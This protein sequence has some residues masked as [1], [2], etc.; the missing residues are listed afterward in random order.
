[1]TGRLGSRF[2]DLR[3]SIGEPFTVLYGP[4]VD[5]TFVGADYQE[6]NLDAALWHLLRA[7]SCAYVAFSSQRRPL[8][9]L[10][11]DSE[12]RSRPGGRGRTDASAPPRT[13]SAESAGPDGSAG[14]AGS[15]GP[16]LMRH[17]R[18]RGPLGRL[19]VRPPTGARNVAPAGERTTATAEPGPPRTLSDPFTVMT[20]SGYLAD[21]PRRTAVV[22]TD[23]ESTLRHTDATRPLDTFFGD[24][25]RHGD[26]DH[27]IVLV[28]A[29]ETFGDCVEYVESLHGYPGL[30]ARLR[31]Q[32]AP[33]A[34][35]GY[36]DEA[37]LH[38][39][40]QRLRLRHGLRIGSWRELDSVVR[41]MAAQP[42]TVKNWRSNLL[43]LGDTPLSGK[44]LAERGW[45]P[46]SA[47]QRSGAPASR[48]TRSAEEQL[49]DL[50]GLE[51]VKKHL[52]ELR[53]RVVNEQLLRAEGRGMDAERGSPHLLFAGPPGTG[54]T[55]VARLVGEMYREM[56]VLSHGDVVEA[57]LDDMIAGYVGQTADQA[58][59]VMDRAMNGVLFLDEVHGLSSENGSFDRDLV[60]PLLTRLENDRD[61]FV[62]IAA[63][64]PDKIDEF[65]ASDHGFPRRFGHRID[66]PDYPPDVLHTILLRY[67]ATSGLAWD[68]TVA[69]QLLQVVT[70]LYATRRPD[71]GNA[72][73]MRELSGKIFT[74]WANRVG[75]D[76][77]QPL[78]IE[79]LPEEYRGL[80]PPPVPAHG[81]GALLAELDHMVGL[82][83]VREAITGLADRIRLRQ[84]RGRSVPA[85][86]NTLFT[87]PP[88][89]GKTS[90]ARAVGTM[91][92]G[93]GL[94]RRGHVVEVTRADLVGE[95]VGHTAPRVRAAVHEALDGVLF[96]DEAY[97]LTAGSAIHGADFGK[98]AIDT[99][100]REMEHWNDRLVVIA[101][102]YS[103]EMDEFLRANSGL[104]S[105]FEL[106]VEFPSYSTEELVEVLRRTAEAESFT[107][108]PEVAERGGRWLDA[109]RRTD[110]TGFGNAR[111][112][113]GLLAAMEA[114]LSRR[115]GSGRAG[116]VPTATD[117]STFTV[118]DVPAPGD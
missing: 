66:F 39:L 70:E 68:E 26:Y 93:L 31:R 15:E 74:G 17:P 50:P 52:K 90:V 22:F 82:A 98:E 21:P 58:N 4:G 61:R 5:D 56:G 44:E 118:D 18:L 42:L 99:L 85:P 48:D 23:A 76:I 63:G 64:Y 113:R 112:V 3:L 10:D 96:I 104:P 55:T 29:R 78:S 71:F 92:R 97:S 94:L 25:A 107:L 34:R 27:P 45:L 72:G 114:R 8:Y 115:L 43:S 7:E 62:V 12:A 41:A 51:S 103:R 35:I 86:P 73:T 108:A 80:L 87:G 75:E 60:R 100:V 2:A 24:W 1:M 46:R 95:Y 83:S 13:G 69:D 38:C 28:F 84:A 53:R 102:G 36:P 32:G 33:S 37:E 88:G 81:N 91:L 89:T 65:L 59:A 54:K 14:P 30:A 9:F 49:N 6:R 101:A 19:V 40:V 110:P 109:R 105:R 79:D 117:Y 11:P 77:K 47:G 20:L 16:G 106:R 111:E 67:L 57:R 116:T